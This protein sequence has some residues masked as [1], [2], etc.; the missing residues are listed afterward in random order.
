[1]LNVKRKVDFSL[2][3]NNKIIGFNYVIDYILS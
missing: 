1:M 3:D 2:I